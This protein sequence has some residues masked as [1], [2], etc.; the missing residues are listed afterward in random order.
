[1][2][3]I[4]V[5]GHPQNVFPELRVA[6]EN[7]DCRGM[8][9]GIRNDGEP[10]KCGG[11]CSRYLKVGRGGLAAMFRSRQGQTGGGLYQHHLYTFSQ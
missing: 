9:V 1:M 5:V 4:S 6:L 10:S 2:I 3:V 11:T 8:L 7:A